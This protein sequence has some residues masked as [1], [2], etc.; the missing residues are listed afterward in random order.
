M[1]QSLSQRM[2]SALPTR[3][4]RLGAFLVPETSFPWTVS[5]NR[6]KVLGFAAMA[7]SLVLISA[8]FVLNVDSDVVA[9]AQTVAA[10]ESTSTAPVIT[11]MAVADDVIVALN[12]LRSSAQTALIAPDPQLQSGA[13][14]WASNV[15]D[16]A[17]V[18]TDRSLRSMLDN[19]STIGEFVVAAP[20]LPIAYERL[21]AIPSQRAQLLAATTRALGVGVQTLGGKTYLVLRFATQ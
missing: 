18:R 17:S 14:A 8:P 4:S 2:S 12:A 13:Q 16:S 6:Q 9:K 15:A 5:R 7:V 19:R 11:E 21:M 3:F 1:D 20:S 10:E